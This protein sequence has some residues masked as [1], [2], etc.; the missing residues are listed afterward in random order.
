MKTKSTALFLTLLLLCAALFTGCEYFWPGKSGYTPV[1]APEIIKSENEYYTE[2]V[3]R[4]TVEK[5]RKIFS[6]FSYQSLDNGN[7]ELN[8]SSTV[9]RN[10][11]TLFKIGEKGEVVIDTTSPENPNYGKEIFYN[12]EV[13]AVPGRESQS[14]IIRITENYDKNIIKEGTLAWFKIVEEKK[15]NV[16]VIPIS[17]LRQYYTINIVG[18]LI[19][20]CREDR[21]INTGIYG[22]ESVEVISGLEE[23]ELIVFN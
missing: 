10:E 20:G 12:A 9:L 3:K 13:I 17:A 11:Y 8:L 6:T 18:V 23:G 14:F 7:K 4:G 5:S 21:E 2:P 22:D 16:I 1:L 19:D 15:E